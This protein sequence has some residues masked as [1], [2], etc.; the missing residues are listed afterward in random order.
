[1][2]PA[3][4]RKIAQ[5]V[6]TARNEVW[7]GLDTIHTHMAGVLADDTLYGCSLDE[8]ADAR[9]AHEWLG[10]LLEWHDKHG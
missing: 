8:T 1:M 10:K 5:L 2:T 4:L 7:R 9:N 6:T 3:A